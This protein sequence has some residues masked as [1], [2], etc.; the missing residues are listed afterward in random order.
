MEAIWPP[1]QPPEHMWEKGPRSHVQGDRVPRTWK[2]GHFRAQKRGSKKGPKKGVFWA[3]LGL[4]IRDFG[5]KS[6]VWR[7]KMAIFGIKE[8]RWLPGA[9]KAPKRPFKQGSFTGIRLKKGLKWGKWGPA[10][11]PGAPFKWTTCKKRTQKCP[12]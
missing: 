7:P 10:G 4:K 5:V 2:R 6:G 3:I 8:G 11:V 12:K 9:E 1:G